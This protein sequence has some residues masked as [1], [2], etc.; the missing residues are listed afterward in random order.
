MESHES[1]MSRPADGCGTTPEV[2]SPTGPAPVPARLVSL[3]GGPEI[4]VCRALIVVGRHPL[5]DVRLD[6]IRVSRRHCCLTEVEGEV[7]VRDLGS[8][9]GTLIN[10]R[11]VEAGR[12]RPGDELTI[13][14]L[15]Y[16]LE[17]GRA[18]EANQV[19][20]PAGSRAGDA[21]LR[22]SDKTS[23]QAGK[24][25]RTHGFCQSF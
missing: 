2:T 20:P 8:L 19:V 15:R 25:V 23:G 16:R 9:N 13:A 14:N 24:P 7:V 17:K 4:S 3:A 11:R 6:S 21:S 22:S 1:M 5:C 18:A 12:L 10:G